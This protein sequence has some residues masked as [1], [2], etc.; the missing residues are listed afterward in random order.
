[1]VYTKAKMAWKVSVNP[2]EKT[3]IINKQIIFAILVIQT[4]KIN[5]LKLKKLKL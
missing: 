4:L 5:I 3:W 2:K 1:M